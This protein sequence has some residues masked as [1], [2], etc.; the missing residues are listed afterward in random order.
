MSNVDPNTLNGTDFSNLEIY[1]P[2][3]LKFKTIK[4]GLAAKRTPVKVRAEQQTYAS[5]NNNQI[6]F[7]MPNGNLYDTRFGYISFNMQL[8]VTGG[9]YLRLQ[10]GIFSCINRICIWFNG[11]LIE[12][13]RDWNRI[14][15]MLWEMQ[16][17][18][19]VTTNVGV[20]LMGF[21]TQ[22]ERNILGPLNSQYCM[23]IWSG[24]LNTE[25]LPVSNL[26]GG[27]W[28]EFYIEQG[29]ACVET[30]GTNPIITITAPILHIE[31]LELDKSYMAQITDY[32]NR[33]G[34][35]IGFNSWQ[36]FTNLLST[37]T[38]TD[39]TIQSKASSVNGMITIQ[40]NSNNLNNT[41]ANDR[42]LTW[43]Q[44]NLYTAQ[45]QLNGPMFP[46]EPI[47][48]QF[49]YGLE[50]Y[51]GYCRWIMKWKTDGILEIA[52]PI[53]NSA[54][55]NDRFLQIMDFEAYPE[56]MDLVNPFTTLQNNG[57]I[58]LTF[59]YS[60]AVPSGYQADTWVESFV[61]VRIDS[62]GSTIVLQ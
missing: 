16:N 14:Y 31:K 53:N 50:A 51:Q 1:I 18:I 47:D 55:F 10:S 29:A 26:S 17:P 24:V 58:V 13:I 57:N 11:T 22:A 32:I 39:I 46:D 42:F 12:D 37:G 2:E 8:S 20:N 60:S 38:R 45:V 43:P 3:T 25:L 19:D 59:T 34:L 4:Q 44:N 52:P 49:A 27:M 5:N 35:I 15:T 9:T 23:P 41:L 30:D 7:K 36:R 48:C 6:K 40:L 56:V 62:N 61:K 28:M 21:G 54:F 33:N